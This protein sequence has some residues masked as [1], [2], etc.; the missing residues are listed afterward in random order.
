MS[1]LSGLAA[2]GEPF[3]GHALAVA[4]AARDK[5]DAV[6]PA[7]LAQITAQENGAAEQQKTNHTAEADQQ[8]S[9]AATQ[10]KTETQ[11]L[12]NQITATKKQHDA[13]LDIVAAK[14]QE[15]NNLPEEIEQPSDTPAGLTEE[16]TNHLRNSLNVKPN[17]ESEPSAA[18]PGQQVIDKIR[19]KI[20][21]NLDYDLTEKER[22]A[23]IRYLEDEF[24]S[25][26]MKEDRA[27]S[28]VDRALHPTPLGTREDMLRFY[29]VRA[30]QQ[31]I[32]NGLRG[33]INPEKPDAEKLENITKKHTQSGKKDQEDFIKAMDRNG[34]LKAKEL[35]ILIIE[36]AR[37]TPIPPGA[38]IGNH[39]ICSDWTYYFE[40]KLNKKIGSKYGTLATLSQGIKFRKYKIFN[41]PLGSHGNTLSDVGWLN[42][43]VPTF[44]DAMN[45][46]GPARNGSAWGV[47]QPEVDP[48]FYRKRYLDQM[49]TLYKLTLTDNTVWYVD[50]GAVQAIL[51]KSGSI[52]T[53]EGGTWHVTPE[54][55]MPA[56]WIP[57]GRT[58]QPPGIPREN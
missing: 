12:D 5:V 56:D 27:R 54:S 28:E 35:A 31:A 51:A 16:E 34:G 22:K 36:T 25:A 23:F 14:A 50:L 7:R 6:A 21:A 41:V 40:E 29:R 42:K 1:G 58:F 2:A 32:Q 26:S 55:R 46:G 9:R 3:S 10:Q 30:G 45:Q 57:T 39:Q 4:G 20:I 13:E 19:E 52:D 8:K 47:S 44:L 43:A 49:H 11:H 24:L 37:E 17:Q 53:L 48:G 38:L 15:K 18:A 33:E